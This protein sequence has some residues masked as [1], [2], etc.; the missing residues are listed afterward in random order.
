MAT[1]P[2]MGWII[3]CRCAFDDG[4]GSSRPYTLEWEEEY[5]GSRCHFGC[6][7]IMNPCQ[8]L[9]VEQYQQ[10]L[11][12]MTVYVCCFHVRCRPEMLGNLQSL[13]LT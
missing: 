5:D 13:H 10:D 3:F 12:G 8:I 11:L 7:H 9:Y 1:E 4:V 2:V 6:W